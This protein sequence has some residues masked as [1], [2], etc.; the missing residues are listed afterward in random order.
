[1]II[2]KNNTISQIKAEQMVESIRE[3]LANGAQ[4]SDLVD[5]ECFGTVQQ[6][7]AIGFAQELLDSVGLPINPLFMIAR[8][9][10][11]ELYINEI[12]SNTIH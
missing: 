9:L 7:L 6:D 2:S 3:W 5:E 4:G 1:M 12:A 10:S 11:P 8:S